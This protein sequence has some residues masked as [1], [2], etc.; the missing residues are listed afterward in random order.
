MSKV[1]WYPGHE[2]LLTNIVRAENCTLI[3]PA[4]TI[5]EEDI[6][7]FLDSFADVLKASGY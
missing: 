1:L 6:D 7:G 5:A 2:L 4:L 3:D